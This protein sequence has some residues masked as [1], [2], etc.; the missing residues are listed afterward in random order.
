VN[1]R[2]DGLITFER[3]GDGLTASER[4]DGRWGTIAPKSVKQ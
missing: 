3:R 2:R 4:R 1:R